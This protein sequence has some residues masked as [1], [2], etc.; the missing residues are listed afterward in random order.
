MLFYMCKKFFLQKCLLLEGQDGQTCKDHVRNYASC[1]LLNVDSQIDPSLVV[2]PTGLRCM[3][4]GKA[5]GATT[6]LIC[7]KC[8][9]GW[10]LRFKV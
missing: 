7:D 1:H 10:Y 8:F 6:M 2:V 4:C 5:L 9:Q 3:L